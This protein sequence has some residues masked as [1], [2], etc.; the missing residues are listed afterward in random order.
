[1]EASGWNASYEHWFNE[2][3]LVNYTYSQVSVDNNANQAA[4]TYDATRYQAASLWWIPVPRLSF[5]VEYIWG[6][7]ENLDGQEAR[8]GR[9]HSLA[10]YNF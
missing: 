1:V 8:A 4:N 2:H 6:K 9:L 7:R 5:A 10:Q 3:W